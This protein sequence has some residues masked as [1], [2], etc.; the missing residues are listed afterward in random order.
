MPSSIVSDELES[1][2][3]YISRLERRVKRLEEIMSSPSPLCTKL[4][5]PPLLGLE[6]NKLWCLYTDGGARPTNPGPAGAGMVLVSPSG[7][8]VWTASVSLGRRTNNY[9]EYAAIA[10]GARHVVGS[11]ADR[12][13]SVLVV[14]SD[15]KLVL[16]C[17]CGKWKC[18]SPGLKAIYTDAMNALASLKHGWKG[19]WVKGHTGNVHNEEADRLATQGAIASGDQKKYRQNHLN[20]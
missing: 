1:M 9:A 3:I 8:I 5:V 2:R 16:N 10:R 19:E 12:V 14:R 7:S 6:D 4:P 11:F 17:L 18:R 13:D 20:K 15:S